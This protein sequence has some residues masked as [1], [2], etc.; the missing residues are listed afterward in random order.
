MKYYALIIKTYNDGTDDKTSLYTYDSLDD[1]V[2]MAHTQ[3]GQN[4]GAETINSVMCTVINSVGGQYSQHTLY[5]SVPAPEPE[6]EVVS[7]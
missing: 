5:W 6:P 1:A 2:A 7:E 4:I 3:Y